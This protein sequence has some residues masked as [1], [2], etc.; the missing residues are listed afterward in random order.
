M[1]IFILFYN[2]FVRDKNVDVTLTRSQKIRDVLNALSKTLS[3]F[4]VV[5]SCYRNEKFG[6]DVISNHWSM[7]K[8]KYVL[9]INQSRLQNE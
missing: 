2:D 3:A 8:Y 1:Q 4:Q 9:I 5:T 6:P 7:N